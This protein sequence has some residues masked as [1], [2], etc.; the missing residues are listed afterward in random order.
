[1]LGTT[2]TWIPQW[3][4]AVDSSI[5]NL[6]TTAD[7]TDKNLTYLT[8][9]SASRGGNVNRFSHLGCFVGASWIHGGKILKNDE[10]LDYGFKLTESCMNTYS[11]SVTGL[12]P[13]VWNFIGNKENKTLGARIDD[14][15][16][17]KEHGFNYVVTT[18]VLRPEVLESV[19]YSYR[20]TGDKRY[21]DFAWAAVS[22]TGRVES[23]PCRLFNLLTS[24]HLPSRHSSH[25]SSPPSSLWSQFKSLLKY[26][27][28]EQGATNSFVAIPSVNDTNTDQFDNQQ[29]FLYAE[30]FKYLYLV[31]SDP[32]VISLDEY[33][34]N[35][36][37]HPFEIEKPGVDLSSAQASNKKGSTKPTAVATQTNKKVDLPFFSN[38]P[39]ANQEISASRTL[40]EFWVELEM[41]WMELLMFWIIF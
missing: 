40:E 26:C 6:I 16:F 22:T 3:I 23:S 19:F 25:L 1:M 14:K 10:Y 35:T 31:F 9:F 29:S 13:E 39:G 18:Y 2:K 41:C 11:S 15:P 20:V 24:F 36:E 37:A 7:Q 32:S 27:K 30:T 17:Y 8:D 28:A 21:Q 34:F 12:G 38:L 4:S 5:A 33:V